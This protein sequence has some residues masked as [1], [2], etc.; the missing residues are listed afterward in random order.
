MAFSSGT[1]SLTDGTRSSPNLCSKQQTA[2]VGGATL[3]DI[4][5]EDI[6][7]GLTK[8][9][10]KDGT[11]TITADIPLNNHK[12]TGLATPSADTD[13]ATRGYVRDNA[14]NHA[15]K[16]LTLLGADF[17]KTY[18]SVV[19]LSD[20][21]T[22]VTFDM[23]KLQDFTKIDATSDP[24]M[25]GIRPYDYTHEFANTTGWT[26]GYTGTGDVAITTQDGYDVVN[27][28]T[29]A[30]N[31]S[32]VSLSKD[33]GVFEDTFTFSCNFKPGVLGT[34]GALNNGNY[35]EFE[36]GYSTTE[37]LIVRVAYDKVQIYRYGT[38]P[39]DIAGNFLISGWNHI[40]IDQSTDND[41]TYAYATIKINNREV[42]YRMFPVD[43]TN[44][45]TD[46]KIMISVNALSTSA[47][48]NCY[49][50]NI[51]INAGNTVVDSEIITGNVDTWTDSD[52][53]S[54][55]IAVTPIDAITINTDLI[56]SISRDDGSTWTDVTLVDSGASIGDT[57]IYSAKDVDIS[58]QPAGTDMQVKIVTDNAKDMILHGLLLS[59]E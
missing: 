51:N 54:V 22:F 40:S 46:G 32:Y 59:R 25:R 6:A 31:G 49:F 23:I 48:R 57:V 41:T 44:T 26:K 35:V 53:A 7:A 19:K 58:A 36:I 11:Q 1:F 30:T 42:C 12:V 38:D 9:I 15:E 45:G 8:A 21:A 3:F 39:V 14:F 5:L 33:F 52:V 50:K 16:L 27:L 10:L 29:G 47:N 18:A 56:V 55:A 43:Y 13:A 20:T 2:G 34:I 28:Y 4:T 17:S 37:R 24:L